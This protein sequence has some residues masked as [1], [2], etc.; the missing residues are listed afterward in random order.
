MARFGARADPP[1]FL[2]WDWIGSWLAEIEAEPVVLI[3]RAGDVVVVLAALIPV[4]RREGPFRADALRLHEVGVPDR[5]II[6]IEYNGLL[7]ARDWVGRG[8]AAALDF[9]LDASRGRR[10][11]AG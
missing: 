3:G 8:E 9:L 4:R 6:S 1:F 7:V 5:D 11:A 10:A 2:S